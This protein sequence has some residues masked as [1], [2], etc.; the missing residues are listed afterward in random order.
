MANSKY[1]ILICLIIMSVITALLR[2]APFALNSGKRK[3]PD[4][5]I[6][7]GRVLPYAIMSMLV[8]FCLKDY[9]FSSLKGS[10]FQIAAATVVVVLQVW[11]KNT[12]ISI[13]GGTLVYMILVQNLL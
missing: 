12:L 7:L 9:M 11:K 10:L 1:Y 4:I 3:T 6:R 8:V 5:V 2:F 13:L